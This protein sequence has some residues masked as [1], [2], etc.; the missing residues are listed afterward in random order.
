MGFVTLKLSTVFHIA[1]LG[2]ADQATLSSFCAMTLIFNSLLAWRL[3][4][5][6]F[7]AVKVLAIF[8]I[9]IGASMVILFAS[10][11]SN[12]YTVTE[13]KELVFDSI[14]SLFLIST[15]IL[16][17]IAFYVSFRIINILEKEDL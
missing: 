7:P 14:S 9:T 17:I 8:F 5:E 13:I 4:G 15:T 2:I 10:Y 6:R 11:E 3:L 12:I 16:A 1:A